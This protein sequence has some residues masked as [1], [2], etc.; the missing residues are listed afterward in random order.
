MGLAFAGPGHA[1]DSPADDK[2]KPTPTKQLELH[3]LTNDELFKQARAMYDRASWDYLAQLRALAATEMQ[4]EDIRR[5][6]EQPSTAP[7]AAARQRKGPS[8]EEEAARK[9]LDA[10]RKTREMVKR[11][12]KWVQNEKE[13]LDRITTRLEEGRSA[14]V[15]FQN[16]LEDLKGFALES[17]LRVKDGSLTEDKVPAELK[18]PFLGKKKQDLLDG[19][20]RLRQRSA[21]VQKEQQQS[22]RHLEEANKAVLAADAE[23]VE[24]SKNLL[25]EQKRQELEKAYHGQKTDALLAELARM[26]EEGI[27]LKGTYELALRKFD[28]QAR[29]CVRLREALDAVKQPDAK[30]PQ[31]TRAEDVAAA[32]Q[33]IRKLIEFYARRTNKIGELRTALAALVEEGREFEADAVV[34][35]EHL[36]KMQVLANLL[37]KNGVANE[38]LPPKAR[39]AELEPAARR[40]KQ[41]ASVVRATTEKAKVELRELTRQRADAETAGQAAAKQLANLKESQEGTLAALHWEGQLKRMAGP[42]VVKVFAA[43]RDE[44]GRKVAK[45]KDAQAAYR[46]AVSAAAEARTR[47]EGLK[48]PFLRAAE[49]KGQ[50]EKQK[51]LEEL[52]KEAGLERAPRATANQP[53]AKKPT[54]MNRL[55]SETGTELDQ[56]A[57]RLAAFQ[58]LLAG[59]VRILEERQARQ[60]DLLAA[61]DR[62]QE[63]AR[64]YAK[65]LAG[66]RRLALQLNATA[67]DIKKRL[68]GGDLTSEHIP[69]G[70]TDALRLELRTKLD[71]EATS[72]LNLLNQLQQDRD[73]LL[74]PDSDGQAVTA[75]TREILT[76][77]GRR[78]DLLA[79]LKRLAAEYR[80]DP[81]TRSPT[82]RKRLDQRAAE[83]QSDEASGWDTVLGIDSSK[84]ARSLAD[85]L[86]SYYRELIEIEDR[87]DLLT[88]QRDKVNQLIELT[89][90]ETASLQRV[91]PLLA[92]QRAEIEAAREEEMVLA[93]A[94][95]RPERADEL[96]KAFQAKTGRLLNKPLPVA[97]K[98]KADKVEELG[99]ALFDRYVR[100]EAG[101]RWSAELNARLT[102]AGIPAEA[103][104]YQDELAQMNAV[105]AAN[106][107]RVEALTG[108]EKPGPATGGE[109]AATRREL[110]RV[111]TEGVKRIG[112]TIAGILLGAILLPR[113][114]LGVLW[115]IFGRKSGDTSS[116]VWAALRTAI[117]AA[118]WV[119][120]LI[121]ILSLL[122][123]NVTAIIAGLGIFGLAVGLAAQPMIA[124]LIGAVVIFAERRFKIGDVIRLGTDNSVRV[125][126]L[127]WRSTQVKNADGLVV[128]IPNRKVTEATIQNLTRATGTFDCLDLSVTTEQDAAK[129]LA[130]LQR[131]M[132]SCENAVADQE[133][134][135]QEFNQKGEAKTIK[136]RFSWFLTD[137]EKRN[138]TRDEVFARI[139]ASLAHEEMAG[140]EIR[141]A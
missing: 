110:A 103:G 109:I 11:K 105:S 126:G 13:L 45:L 29:Q 127:T 38:E 25:R 129:V 95:L 16:T 88:K 125:V 34:S 84:T 136:Y 47:L 89:R 135:V 123:V 137:Y 100:L 51:L 41:S 96:L 78:L 7:Q 46:K 77:V 50:V 4:L 14:T 107:R 139:S 73:K 80:R 140:T 18:P 82:E 141:L 79:D 98:D 6:I 119:A 17:A 113:L 24:A 42:Q 124:D 121:L 52:R 68:G 49:E 87:R 35:E 44:L 2:A 104:V 5:Q 48:D 61:I 66:A 85:L 92:R 69:D 81:A 54:P 90:K 138:Q 59:R 12:S 22:A 58:Q 28:A 9:A 55:R 15:A 1:A 26:V 122:G 128:T 94:R 63:K 39:A 3:R 33:S 19:M 116:L 65:M 70:V 53:A 120:A 130:V 37:R 71:A 115:W 76:L 102:P 106:R 86:E 43:T 111:R 131:A 101:Q 23:V 83:R 20:A 56:V 67:V 112:L 57:D 60:K 108:Q 93:R 91:M 36:F 118:V 21:E 10:A 114:L 133:V 8:N 134:S 32:T 132:E 74:R 99:R 64:A 72:V 27:G 30:I 117:K 97:D 40:Q 62:L 31:V 75:A